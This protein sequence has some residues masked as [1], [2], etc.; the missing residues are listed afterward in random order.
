MDLKDRQNQLKKAKGFIKQVAPKQETPD[1][2][3]T[4]V[5]KSPSRA[6]KSDNVKKKYATWYLPLELIQ[7]V[8]VEAAKTT[9][10]G[11]PAHLVEKILS[12]YFDAKETKEK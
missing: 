11:R 10:S 2:K 5:K 8:R 4:P 1:E 3:K 12:E 6:R 7:K 9:D